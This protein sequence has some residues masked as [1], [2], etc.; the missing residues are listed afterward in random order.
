LLLFTRG[1]AIAWGQELRE[2]AEVMRTG[3][4]LS[5]VRRR[6]SFFYLLL[7]LTAS[8]TSFLLWNHYLFFG[9]I[10]MGCLFTLG[11]VDASNAKKTHESHGIEVECSFCGWHEHEFRTAEEARMALGNHAVAH[12]NFADDGFYR[13]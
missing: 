2:S 3:R 6:R 1:C 11:R 4:F 8:A 13:N 10:G 5:D 12:M 9:A 7:W